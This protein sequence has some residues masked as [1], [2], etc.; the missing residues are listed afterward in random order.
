MPR[1]EADAYACRLIARIQRD[2]FDTEAVLALAAHYESQRDLPSLANLMEGWAQTLREPGTAAGA[3]IA[4]A[5]AALAATSDRARARRLYQRA[6]ERSPQ[7]ALARTR[8]EALDKAGRSTAPPPPPR[9]I[10]E[11]RSVDGDAAWLDD[12]HLELLEDTRAC[13]YE[14]TQRIWRPQA[15]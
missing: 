11:I 8:L 2:Q 10:S 12:E 9:A 3:Y 14:E 7:H 4:A 6:L 13:R 15:R 1:A 5:D